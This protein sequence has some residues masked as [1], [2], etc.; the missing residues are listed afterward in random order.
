MC[1][2]VRAPVELG[3]R[4]LEPRAS[5]RTRVGICGHGRFNQPVEMHISGIGRALRDTGR[6][7]VIASFLREQRKR[8]TCAVGRDERRVEQDLVRV[9]PSQDGLRIEQACIELEHA[10]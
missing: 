5:H 4:Q 9:P 10:R 2:M 8:A 3:E 7:H 6:Q 1:Q